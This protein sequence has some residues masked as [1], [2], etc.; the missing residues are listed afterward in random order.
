ME[1]SLVVSKWRVMSR[2]TL[3]IGL[4][5]LSGIQPPIG[6][7]SPPTSQGPAFV[8]PIVQRDS[9]L[10]G[11]LIGVVEEPGTGTATVHLRVDSGAMLDLAGRGGLAD[12]TAAMLF[13]DGTGPSPQNANETLEQLG[14]K[15]TV[16]V[17]WDSTDIEAVGPADTLSAIFDLL[18]RA[19]IA[20]TFA[21]KQLDSVRA[22]RIAAIKETQQDDLTLVKEKALEAVYGS[23]PYGRPKGGTAESL[24]KITQAD[25]VY[26][27][28]RF[29]LANNSQLLVSG[30]VT[31]NEVTRLA[32]SKLGS[33]KKGERVPPTFRAPDTQTTRR[34][35]IL[36]RPDSLTARLAVFQNGISRRADDYFA[37]AVMAQLLSSA[38]SR[39]SQP[40][41]GVTISIEWE[42]R[43]LRGPLLVTGQCPL[44]S[45]PATITAILNAMDRLRKTPPA[46]EQLED[47]KS[48]TIAAMTGRLRSSQGTAGALLDIELY[49]LGRD[50]LINLVDRINAIT[51]EN[52]TAAARKYLLPETVTI[53]VL[54]PAGKLRDPLKGIGPVTVVK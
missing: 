6:Y 52:A 14:V 24:A 37:A 18:G 12:L 20:P 38:V 39:L 2:L 19:V 15:T 36:D 30:D 50:Y 35:F 11:L 44:E 40:S 34:V 48:R 9:L 47:A 46:A 5:A 21:K 22:Q 17:S 3:I 4:V 23:H 32:R 31:A 8:L 49:A 28:D 51:G 53:V 26:Y 43:I 13:S 33:W 16:S 27:H 10:N 54:G 41:Q 45:T 1:D 25:L 29:Y 42:A 7:T